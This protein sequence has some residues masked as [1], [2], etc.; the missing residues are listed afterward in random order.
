MK[1]SRAL[2]GIIPLAICLPCLVPLL[3][4]FG[5]GAGAFS[6]LGAWLSNNGLVLGAAAT[7]ALAFAALAGI[8]YVRRSR[9]AACEPR[10][11]IH[12]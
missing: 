12:E 7:T 4:A 10:V 6:G 8:F 2:T 1:R 9:A 5:I 3:I 11:T